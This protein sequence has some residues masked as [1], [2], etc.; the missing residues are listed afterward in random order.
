M[1]NLAF[2]SFLVFRVNVFSKSSSVFIAAFSCLYEDFVFGSKF[3]LIRD[4]QYN[5]CP[6]SWARVIAPETVVFLLS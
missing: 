2:K 4:R 3:L 1:R 6:Y 5:A